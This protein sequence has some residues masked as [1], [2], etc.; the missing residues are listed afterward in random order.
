MHDQEQIKQVRKALEE[1][2]QDPLKKTLEH[3]PERQ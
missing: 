2:E 3:F 1:W